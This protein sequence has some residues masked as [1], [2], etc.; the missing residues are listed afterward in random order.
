MENIKK[1]L[2]K[3]RDDVRLREYQVSEI[4]FSGGTYGKSHELFSHV[5]ELKLTTER[6]IDHYKK[7]TGLKE[8]DIRKHLLP[9]HDVWLSAKEAKKLNLCDTIKDL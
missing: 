6:M 5:T 8:T 3:F 1:L 4:Q 7:C 9:P 2:Q